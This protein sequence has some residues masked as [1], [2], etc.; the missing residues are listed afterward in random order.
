MPKPRRN[1]PE[2]TPQVL[3]GE[4]IPFVHAPAPKLRRFR[5]TSARAIRRE[6]AALYA[7]FR[8]GSIDADGA[9]TGAFILRCLL[10]SVRTD[11]LESR[12]VALE[13]LPPEAEQ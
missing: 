5:L 11:E 13:N 7:E 6:L 12:I 8:N 9:R 4:V 1:A 10:E 3:D 2:K